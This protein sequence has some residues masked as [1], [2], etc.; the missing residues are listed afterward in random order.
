MFYVFYK[1]EN[2]YK[3]SK[4]IKNKYFNIE[5]FKIKKLLNTKLKYYNFSVRTIN[6]LHNYNIY[7]WKDLVILKK[8]KLLKIKNFGKK[9]LKELIKKMKKNNLRFRMNIK[10]YNL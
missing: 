6:C 4:D 3:I 5:Y 9:S 8:K 7:K 1:K 2:Y 10:K